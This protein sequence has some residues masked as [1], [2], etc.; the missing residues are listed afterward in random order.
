MDF[1]LN[2]VNTTMLENET[3][4]IAKKVL[5]FNGISNLMQNKTAVNIC[6]NAE[7]NAFKIELRL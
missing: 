2:F 5:K 3:I 4:K 1:E 7:A 6:S